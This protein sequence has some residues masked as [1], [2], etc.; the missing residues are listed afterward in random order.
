M[1]NLRICGKFLGAKGSGFI[2]GPFS[3]FPLY[4]VPLQSGLKEKRIEFL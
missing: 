2:S 4:K 3:R 1:I